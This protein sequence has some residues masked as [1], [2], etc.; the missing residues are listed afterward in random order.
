MAEGRSNAGIA[1]VLH[2]AEKT[3]AT[4]SVTSPRTSAATGSTR[5]SPRCSPSPTTRTAA[6]RS[7]PS[8]RTWTPPGSA[9]PST[10]PPASRT[11]SCVSPP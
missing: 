3:C 11:H 1:R 5:P 2:L 8:R 6:R 9:G 10:P 4:A 7:A